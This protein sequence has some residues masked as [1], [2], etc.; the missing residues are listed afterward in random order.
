T[1][2]LTSLVAGLATAPVA[3][4]HFHRMSPWGLVANLLAVPVMGAWIAPAGAAAALAAPFGQSGP[5]LDLMALGIGWVLRVAHEVA[6]LPGADRAIPAMPISLLVVLALAGLWIALW[7][8]PWRFAGVPVIATTLALAPAVAPQ[9]PAILIAPGGGLVGVLHRGERRLDH[10]R[11]E[12]YAAR[13][14]LESD[15]D[16]TAQIDAAARPGMEPPMA[17]DATRRPARRSMMLDLALDP[18]VDPVVDSGFDPRNDREDD[19]RDDQAP[20]GRDGAWRIVILRGKAATAEAAAYCAG[21]TVVVAPAFADTTPEGCVFIGKPAL[22]SGQAR[23][24]VASAD[25]LRLL[26]LAP[27]GGRP[28]HGAAYAAQVGRSQR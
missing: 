4:I 28:W 26:P 7:R 15:G 16:R 18:V 19:P 22:A 8:G 17:A 24:I 1:V 14:W 21:R 25:G 3:A 20:V 13:S 2:S 9:R 11:A 6:A 12:S 5:L 27:R 23:A 10:P